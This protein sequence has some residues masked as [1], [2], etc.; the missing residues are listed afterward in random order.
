MVIAKLYE[1]GRK[2]YADVL[3]ELRH[4]KYQIF[5]VMN[6]F[7]PLD[8]SR[9]AQYLDKVPEYW[10][11]EKDYVGPRDYCNFVSCSDDGRR[12]LLKGKAF[13]PVLVDVTQYLSSPLDDDPYTGYFS[14]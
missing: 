3:W 6:L 7:V 5:N 9:E 14:S 13:A 10:W 8:V 12:I 4:G 11:I 2:L 1:E